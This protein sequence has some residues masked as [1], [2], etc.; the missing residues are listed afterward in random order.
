MSPKL[1]DQAE[2]RKPKMQKPGVKPGVLPESYLSFLRVCGTKLWASDHAI[3]S[4]SS[5]SVPLCFKGLPFQTRTYVALPLVVSV[6]R[7]FIPSA[8]NDS[9]VISVM[10]PREITQ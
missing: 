1:R 5:P 10:I 7:Q 9:S 4:S 3:A 8:I 6:F 2:G